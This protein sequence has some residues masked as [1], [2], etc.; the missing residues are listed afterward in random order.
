MYLKCAFL[1]Y[2]GYG[3]LYS[4]AKRGIHHVIFIITYFPFTMMKNAMYL[5]QDRMRIKVS[6]AGLKFDAAQILVVTI[7]HV[8]LILV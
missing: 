7:C 5:V 1:C 8:D 6:E 4:Y 3:S 2:L